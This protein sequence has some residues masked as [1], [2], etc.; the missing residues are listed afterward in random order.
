M[1]EAEPDLP[2][3]STEDVKAP[4]LVERAKEEIEA[5][6]HPKKSYHHKETHGTSDDIDENT[7]ADEVKAPGF[8]ERAKEEIEAIIHPKKSHHHK[9]THGTS[10]DID[11]N[12]PVDEV[13]APGFLERAKEEIEAIIHPKKSHHHKETHGTSDD[14]DENTPV[15]EVKAPGFLERAKEEIEA[16]VEAVHPKKESADHASPDKSSLPLSRLRFSSLSIAA[17]PDPL[18]RLHQQ[19]RTL[20]LLPSQRLP[21]SLIAAASLPI[22]AASPSQKGQMP[23]SFV[24]VVFSVL[25]HVCIVGRAFR[26]SLMAANRGERS[27]DSSIGMSANDLELLS[28]LILRPERKAVALWTVLFAWDSSELQSIS[29]SH[30]L[31]GLDDVKRKENVS[32]CE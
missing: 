23:D 8:L 15:D 18:L 5:I 2:N 25:I 7:P 20:S 14:I 16:L 19:H 29:Y 11:E 26:S 21:S 6:I 32:L 31:F 30:S 28:S 17:R 12:T 13:K 10:D 27:S 22:A 3:A 9:E 4:N 24:L 1:S